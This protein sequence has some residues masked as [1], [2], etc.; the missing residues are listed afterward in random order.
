MLKYIFAGMLI[1]GFM[2]GALTGQAAETTQAAMDG[3][4][5]AIELGIVMCG[6]YALWMG[7]FEVA[8]EAG[9]VEKIA[10]GFARP[11]R[12]LFR[13]LPKNSPA[14][15]YIA[16]NLSA[17][18]LGLGNAAT[19]SGIA[20]MHALQEHNPHPTV[21]TRAMCMLLIVNSASIQIIPT[22]VMAVRRAAGSQ[23][24]GA[25][26]LYTLFST[27]CAMT[28][29]IVAGKMMERRHGV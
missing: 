6:M 28:V 18:M 16:L 20:A 13:D 24:P 9:L 29:A 8:Q 3:A 14:L 10:K 7:I 19:P 15:G 25:I 17:N 26:I 4:A 1:V 27:L 2:I 21:A 5:Q 12:F 11:L 22:G 23:D